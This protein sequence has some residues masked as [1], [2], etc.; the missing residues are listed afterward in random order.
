MVLLRADTYRQFGCVT[1]THELTADCLLHG[2][3]GSWPASASG[4]YQQQQRQQHDRQEQG[5]GRH[6]GCQPAGAPSSTARVGQGT[7]LLHQQR[8]NQQQLLGNAQLL[9]R[10]ASTQQRCLSLH[11]HMHADRAT[12]TPIIFM[13]HGL[14]G[15]AHTSSRWLTSAADAQQRLLLQ[16]CWRAV[17]LRW[18]ASRIL[19][20][21]RWAHATCSSC[22]LCCLHMLPG[23]WQ[24][25]QAAARTRTR[26]WLSCRPLQ[27]SR[28]A[29]GPGAVRLSAPP[30]GDKRG[31]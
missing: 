30:A 4:G 16:R 11:V 25:W 2:V 8:H 13:W 5:R 27:L 9:Q 12:Q 7:A 24:G 23:C 14:R 10:T 19:Q 21:N 18:Y 31:A 3:V 22:C 20:Q 29:A 28:G 1:S 26:R 15:L 6:G 17:T